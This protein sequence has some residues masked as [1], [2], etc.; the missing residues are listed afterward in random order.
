MKTGAGESSKIV[1][2]AEGVKTALA[3]GGDEDWF[4][5]SIEDCFGGGKGQQLL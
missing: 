2:I 5:R 3:G 4:G 1:L